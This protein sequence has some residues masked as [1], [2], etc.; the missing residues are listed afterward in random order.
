[1]NCACT[2]DKAVSMPAAFLAALFQ[3]SWA[4]ARFLLNRAMTRLYRF[5]NLMIV[6]TASA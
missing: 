2:G 3:V 1:M 5:R 4:N 6:E